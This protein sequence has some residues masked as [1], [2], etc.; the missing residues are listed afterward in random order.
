MKTHLPTIIKV[1][2][3]EAYEFAYNSL[4]KL[5][6]TDIQGYIRWAKEQNDYNK[7]EVKQFIKDVMEVA[8][9]VPTPEEL[10]KWEFEELREKQLGN[11]A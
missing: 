4:Y 5:Q 2:S 6:P 10:K 9:F 1:G 11:N 7:R 8:E 3:K